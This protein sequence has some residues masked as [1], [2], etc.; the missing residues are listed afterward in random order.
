MK[1][2]EVIVED[3]GGQKSSNGALVVDIGKKQKRKRIKQL[4]KGKGK[5][6]DK[7]EQTISELRERKVIGENAQTVVLVVRQ[8]RKSVFGGLF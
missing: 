8:K 2:Q 3:V 1:N 7:I 6:V 4:R 5:L